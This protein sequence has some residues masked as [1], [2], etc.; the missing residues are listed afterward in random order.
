MDNEFTGTLVL[1]KETEEIS[2]R[3][4]KREFIV[5]DD[6][7]KYEQLI[8]FEL[9][10][11][12]V[13]LILGLNPGD[14]IKVGFNLRGRE[15]IDNVGNKKYFNTLQ[16]WRVDKL[17][18][19]KEEDSNPDFNEFDQAEPFPGDDDDIHSGEFPVDNGDDYIDK[20]PF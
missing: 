15:W 1:I 10:Q 20:I 3:F 4:Q 18:S 11:D 5:S 8:S 14:K 12:K 6:D 9:H 7:D 16:A 2:D 17:A 19:A 13:D